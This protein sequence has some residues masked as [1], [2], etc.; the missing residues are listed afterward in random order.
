LDF[1]LKKTDS[2][3]LRFFPMFLVKF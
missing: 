3:E 2:N 1:F